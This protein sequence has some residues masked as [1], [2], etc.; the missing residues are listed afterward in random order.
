MNRFALLIPLALGACSLTPTQQTSVV[1]AV[2]TLASV[3]ASQ[4]T[5]AATILAKG[6][7][8]CGYINS[9]T[10]QLEQ[11]GA[12]IIAN[13]AGVPL[14]VTNQVAADVAAAC[15]AGQSPGVLPVTANIATVPVLPTAAK[16]PPVT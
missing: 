11:T 6:A 12:E 5:T 10:G 2:N 8:I 14:S 7:L 9:T 4:N 3:A 13:A 15:P 16:L 1:T